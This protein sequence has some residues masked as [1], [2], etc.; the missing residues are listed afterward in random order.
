[1]KQVLKITMAIFAISTVAIFA[2]CNSS[3]DKKTT[4]T[5]TTKTEMSHEGGEHIFACPMHPEVTGKEGDTCP[6]CGM[7]LE[8]NDNAGG[9]SNV[10]MQFTYNPA[11]PK[12]G[13]E[14][15]LS[16]T[17]KIKDKPTEQVPLD[18]EHTKKKYISLWLVMTL[19]GLTTYILS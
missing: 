9:P 12:P 4:S 19:A 2:A 17:P 14:V 3:G 7:K 11:S 1:M 6:K 13:E 18:V 10:S 15:T 8:H 5:D 16:M